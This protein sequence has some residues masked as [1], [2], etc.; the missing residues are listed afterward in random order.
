VGSK[1]IGL[2]VNT[3]KSKY[4]VMSPDQNAVSRMWGYGLDRAGSG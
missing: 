4:M 3:E 2:K 1:E